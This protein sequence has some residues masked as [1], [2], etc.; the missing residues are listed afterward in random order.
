MFQKEE[1]KIL[2]RGADLP[3]DLINKLKANTSSIL[4]FNEFLST[5]FKKDSNI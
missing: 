3:E 1:K 2:Y 5:T 4:I